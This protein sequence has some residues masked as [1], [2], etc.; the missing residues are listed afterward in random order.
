MKS[1]KA[2]NSR[3]GASKTAPRQCEMDLP[4][5]THGGARKG[6]GR[7]KRPGKKHDSVHRARPIIRAYQPQ[8]VVMR[9]K[10]GVPKLRQ[11]RAYR[12]VR[13]SLVKCLGKEEFRVCHVSIQGN[14][15]HF[16][17]EAAHK[18]ALSTGMQG[19][20]IL[21]SRALN[22]ELG[23]K[24]TLFAF[25]YHAT[26]I[27]NPRQARNSLAYVLNNW[28]RHREDE[29]CERAKYAKLDP[30]ASGL[31]FDGWTCTFETPEDFTPLPVAEPKTWLLREGW[32]RYGAIHPR[33][34]PG[35]MA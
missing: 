21:V 1:E 24:G 2:R 12:A 4:R 34:V 8:H 10:K 6:A 16:I 15:L 32:K 11:G 5:R 23:R 17:I 14:H 13:K 20:N 22:R 25:R 30:Y 7:P 29:N 33:E 28:R 19:L 31:S 18:D 9:V 3:R 26:A 27:T 35:P